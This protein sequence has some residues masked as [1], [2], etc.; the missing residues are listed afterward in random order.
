VDR[1]LEQAR[2]EQD[3]EQRL[4]LYGQA[5]QLIVQDAALVP[6][7]HSRSYMLTK[8]YVKGVVYSAAIRPGLKDVYLER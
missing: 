2:V 5:E 3:S 7:W 4:Q 6:L 1:L 8:P